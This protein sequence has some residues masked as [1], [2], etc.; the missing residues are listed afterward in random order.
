MEGCTSVTQALPVPGTLHYCIGLRPAVLAKNQKARSEVVI[1]A[2]LRV[3]E[4]GCRGW[5][6][7][8]DLQVMSLMRPQ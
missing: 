5:I 7:T 3:S 1:L 6:R 8:N 2:G 4:I